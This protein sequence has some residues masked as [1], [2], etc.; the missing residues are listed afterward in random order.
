MSLNSHI[1]I[2]FDFFRLQDVLNNLKKDYA[3]MDA[4]T[5]TEIQ[6]LT[7]QI[8]K[9]HK[10]ILELEEK[11]NQFTDVNEK[12]YFQVWDMNVEI[13]ENLLSEVIQLYISMSQ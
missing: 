9:L 1:F 5:K 8:L 10:N 4:N 12:K 7:D 2:S 11:S 6:K 3:E 13:A